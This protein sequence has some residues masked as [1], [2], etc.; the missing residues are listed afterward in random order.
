MV[1]GSV[2]AFITYLRERLCAV[3]PL[4]HVIIEQTQGEGS[5][6]PGPPDQVRR[7]WIFGSDSGSFRTPWIR[8]RSQGTGSWIMTMWSGKYC[9]RSLDQRDPWIRRL[10][11]LDPL[12][13]GAAD[14][15]HSA[16][17]VVVL[18]LRLHINVV[19][20]GALDAM[21]RAAP[22]TFLTPATKRGHSGDA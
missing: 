22:R 1:P 7:S 14:A 2:S 5:G 17:H 4:R 15:A 3:Q 11:S 19:S 20:T 6:S 10:R 8:R 16:S 13:Q 9:P 18:S 21:L 12:D